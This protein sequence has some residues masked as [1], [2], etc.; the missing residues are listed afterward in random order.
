VVTSLVPPGADPAHVH[1]LWLI[2]GDGRPRSLGFV[3]PGRSK[4]I[5]M[6]TPMADLVAAGSALAVS[7]EPP[8]GSTRADGPSGPIAAQGKLAEI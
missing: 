7:V 4:A 8:G 1:Q 5:A 6:S 2:P 3:E